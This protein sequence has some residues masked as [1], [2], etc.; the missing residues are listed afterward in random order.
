MKQAEH[1]LLL[2]TD[3]P[4]FQ[5]TN[6]VLVEKNTNISKTESKIKKN[7]LTKHHFSLG[8]DKND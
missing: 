7:D 1:K 6:Q 5:T 4:Q 8:N 3:A 2:G